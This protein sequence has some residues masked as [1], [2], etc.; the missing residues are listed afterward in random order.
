PVEASFKQRGIEL[1][2]NQ[3]VSQFEGTGTVKKVITDKGEYNADLVVMC[4]GF[5][6]N[7]GLFKGQI[8]MLDN[9]AIIV[10]SYM[11]TSVQDV[12]AAGD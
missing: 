7:T 8:E 3:T 4:V 10:D 5:R 9:G 2:L 12:Y 11:R 6:P 1:A